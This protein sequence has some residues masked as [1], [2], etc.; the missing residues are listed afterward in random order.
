VTAFNSPW[1]LVALVLAAV[2][3]FAVVAYMERG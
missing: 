1:A 3:A 2:V